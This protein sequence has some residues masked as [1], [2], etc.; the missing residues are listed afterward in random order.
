M[1]VF[2]LFVLLSDYLLVL[3]LEKL[4]LFF[5]VCHNLAKTFLEEIDLGFE[6]LDFFVLFK[7]LLCM[8][9]HRLAFLSQIRHSLLVIE[10]KLRIFVV[11]IGQFF[12]LQLRFLT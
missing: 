7:L 4:P 8:F 3:E 12:V 1:Q 11:Q 9:L 2:Q 5:K 10:F 6:Q